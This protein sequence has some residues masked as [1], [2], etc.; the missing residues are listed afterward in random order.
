MTTEQQFL[1]TRDVSATQLGLYTETIVTT[2]AIL[3]P[4]LLA[5]AESGLINS[6]LKSSASFLGKIILFRIDSL[7]MGM[8]YY[9][10]DKLI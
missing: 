2:I 3:T 6:F 7:W 9:H 1:R 4:F 8:P 5:A 10:M